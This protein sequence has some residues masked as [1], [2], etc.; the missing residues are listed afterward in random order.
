MIYLEIF[1]KYQAI[2][3]DSINIVLLKKKIILVIF[4]FS[5]G[6]AK[7]NTRFRNEEILKFAG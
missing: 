7:K 2:I 5:I 6:T 4:S 1:K 3:E